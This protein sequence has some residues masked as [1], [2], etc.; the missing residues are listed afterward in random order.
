MKKLIALLAVFMMFTACSSD[1]DNDGEDPI[2]GT[3]Y[4][5]DLENTFS[6][7]ELT[8]CNMNSNITFKADNTADSEFYEQVDGECVFEAE[9][10]EWERNANGQY[11]L[12]LPFFGRQTGDVEF[13][14]N[15]LFK[16]SVPSLPGVSLTFE[17]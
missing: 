2:L 17:K 6:D 5:V 12:V 3:W 11:T 14:G 8:E 13:I 9:T 7:D 4:V 10:A 15:N 1:D 16:F